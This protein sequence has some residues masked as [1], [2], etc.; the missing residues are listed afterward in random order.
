MK[1]L[2]P[3][4]FILLD[5]LFLNNVFAYK[6]GSFL[7][8]VDPVAN[9][10][11]EPVDTAKGYAHDDLQQTQV[12]YNEALL[13]KGEN[14]DWYKVEA[15]EQ[16]EFSQHQI[17]QG[18]PGWINKKSVEFIDNIP[19]YNSVVKNK[20]AKI[21][22]AP[23]FHKKVV[24]TV[25]MGTRFKI[26]G[27]QGGYYKVSLAGNKIGW[28]KKE[29][30]LKFDMKLNRQQLG[31]NLLFTAKSFVNTPYLWGGRSMFMPELDIAVTG[32]DCSGL[33]SLAYRANNID[34]PRDAHEQ[35][36]VAQK[37]SAGGRKAG[38]LIFISAKGYF[39][40]ITHVMLYIKGEYFIES[41][42][43]GNRVGIKKFKKKFGV[44]LSE[45]IKQDCFIDNQKIYFGR[46]VF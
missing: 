11:K 27:Q 1:V 32:V 12:L 28:T 43:T 46:V 38:D 42:G 34:I 23:V 45:L 3:I 4:F 24:L 35:W 8:V 36:M 31:K 14:A 13:Y 5:F 7:I 21:Y 6:E 25:S 20:L 10:K 17:W 33:T 44:T 15:M 29:N 26:I 16:Q 9:L 22:S 2:I 41:S 37:V 39:D 30:L 18:Y 40:K 19:E